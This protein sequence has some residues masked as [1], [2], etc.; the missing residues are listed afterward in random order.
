MRAVVIDAV[1]GRPEVRDVAE[2]TAPPD[3]VVVRVEATGLCR[4]DWHAWAGHDEIAL[5]HVP[6][7]ELAGVIVAVGA[8]VRRWSTGD[9][10]TVPFV[11]GCGRCARCAAGDQQVCEHQTQPGFT[12]WGSFA[13]LVSLDAADLNLVALPDELSF[14]VAASLGCRYGTV[15]PHHDIP[16]LVELYKAGRLKLDELVS[17]TYAPDDVEQALTDMHDGKLNRGVLNFA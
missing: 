8:G 4:S 16:M 14:A 5:P 1:R 3:G 11:C 10:V 12:H 6:G 13:E 7:H 9:R 2:P 17:A 15:R